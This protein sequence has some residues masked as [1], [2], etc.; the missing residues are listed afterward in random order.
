MLQKLILYVEPSKADQRYWGKCSVMLW[1]FRCVSQFQI[2]CPIVLMSYQNIP[3]ISLFLYSD[4]IFHM[5]SST[6]KQHKNLADHVSEFGVWKM[7]TLRKETDQQLLFSSIEWT[8]PACRLHVMPCPGRCGLINTVLDSWNPSTR[9]ASSTLSPEAKASYLPLDSVGAE[10]HSLLLD[11]PL[12]TPAQS[13]GKAFPLLSLS[14]G[15]LKLSHSS[16]T[17]TPTAWGQSPP[18]RL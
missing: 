3:V 10:D 14:Y 1:I 7:F 17:L 16:V 2:F 5:A 11:L 6:Q 15:E 18:Q 9:R 13:P 4:C 12:A 8:L